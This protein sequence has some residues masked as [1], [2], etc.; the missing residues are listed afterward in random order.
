MIISDNYQ[1]FAIFNYETIQW[2]SSTILGGN[3]E[4]GTGG[5]AAKVI[6]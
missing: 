1:S 3:P 2:Y 6:I 5:E 4:T